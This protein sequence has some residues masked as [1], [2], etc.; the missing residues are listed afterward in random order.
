MEAWPTIRELARY[1]GVCELNSPDSA[2]Y[3]TARRHKTRHAREFEIAFAT[4]EQIRVAFPELAMT[5][6]LHHPPCG[7]HDNKPARKRRAFG[8]WPANGP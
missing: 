1:F 5:L 6:D 2:P 3:A 4:F 8:R 7:V